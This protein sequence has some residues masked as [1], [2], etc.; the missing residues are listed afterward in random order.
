M[1][2]LFVSHVANFQK[3]NK[4]YMLWFKE[5]GWTVDYAAT[6]DEVILNADN[7]Y[8]IDFRRN[9]LNPKN[10]KALSQMIKLL[11]KNRYDII[12]CHTPVGGVIA[13]VAALFSPKT[14]VIYTAHG[15]HF[16]KGAPLLNN[17][18]YKTIERLLAGITD[19]LVTINA[20]DYNAAKKFRLR[21]NGKVYYLKGVGV[22]TERYANSKPDKEKICKEL[23]IKPTDFI[24]LTVG[25]LIKRKNYRSSIA[26]FAE[27]DIPDSKY[28]ICG[29]GRDEAELKELCKEYGIEDKV[30]FMGYCRNIEEI[31]KIADV[32]ML[33]SW[34][35]GLP[36]AILEAMAGGLPII[37][38][39][40]RGT[41]ELVTN[42]GFIYKPDDIKSFSDALKKLYLNSSLRTEMGKNS[43]LNSLEYDIHNSVKTM[44]EIYSEVIEKSKNSG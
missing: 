6:D 43:T 44:A 40:I 7:S 25:E 1:K 38:S 21:K 17:I 27:A 19:V 41:N 35:E 24:V 28:L 14:K 39:D 11:K 22:D 34:Q 42:N 37:G 3:F 29:K 20:E 15:F 32:F 26:A 33:I 30:I 16:F 13:R 31:V 12:H 36:L 4:P 10:I 8:T 23:N 9:P 2:I 5:Q 18:V